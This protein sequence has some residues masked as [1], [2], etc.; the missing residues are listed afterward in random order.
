RAVVELSVDKVE[1]GGHGGLRSHLPGE[2]A[3]DDGAAGGV[4][5]RL[6]G[7][8]LGACGK[9]AEGGEQEQRKAGVLRCHGFPLVVLHS[10]SVK[11][12]KSDSRVSV[13]GVEGWDAAGKCAWGRSTLTQ[14]SRREAPGFATASLA[15]PGSLGVLCVKDFAFPMR[16]C[17]FRLF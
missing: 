15:K 1:N 10:N 5:D 17:G 13:G 14:S 7:S 6:E 16:R 2:R 8:V 12:G 9:G 3:I 4:G 11:A